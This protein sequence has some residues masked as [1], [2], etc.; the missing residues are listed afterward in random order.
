MS[1][2]QM[3]HLS[4]AALV[5]L[6]TI[7]LATLADGL[8]PPSSGT[9][10][11]AS[12][13]SVDQRSGEG[14]FLAANAASMMLMMQGMSIAPT[15]NED[16]DFVAMMIPHHQGAIDMAMAELRYGHNEQLK[17]LAQEI[18]ITQKQEIELMRLT[19]AALTPTPTPSGGDYVKSSTGHGT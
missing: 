9:V 11:Y 2:R 1:A 18:I 4:R 16:R 6:L 7:G 12:T 13:A 14:P 5:V 19:N 3:I 10:G 8:E 15:G 17:R